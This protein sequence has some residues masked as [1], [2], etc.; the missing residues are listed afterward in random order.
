MEPLRKTI[1][2]DMGV[3]FLLTGHLQ[4][5]PQQNLWVNPGGLFL[6]DLEVRGYFRSR[7]AGFSEPHFASAHGTALSSLPKAKPEAKNDSVYYT[8]P[9]HGD[10]YR[11]IEMD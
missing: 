5:P 9:W 3:S 6:Q 2:G 1:P 10:R 4:L 7:K 8:R 11:G